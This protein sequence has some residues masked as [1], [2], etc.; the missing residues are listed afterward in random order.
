MLIAS[1]IGGAAI[2]IFDGL[3]K[4]G[5]HCQA[6]CDLKRYCQ[7]RS[8]SSVYM[9]PLSVLTEALTLR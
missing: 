5:L 7:G 6:G 8:C 4:L 3:Q 9:S 1:G 2:A